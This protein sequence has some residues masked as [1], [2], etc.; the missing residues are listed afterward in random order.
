MELTSAFKKLDRAL[1][2]AVIVLHGAGSG[3]LAVMMFFTTAD[4]VLRY[5]FGNPIKGDYEISAF[6]MAIVIP[7]G[8]AL[9]ALRKRH[10]RVDVF[11][12]RLPRRVQAGLSVLA[13]LITLGLVCLMAWQG[14]KYAS[15]LHASKT[16]A[17]SI[18]V[19]HYPFVIVVTVC[20]AVFAVVALRHVIDYARQAITG[21]VAAEEEEIGPGGAE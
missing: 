12:M 6:M 5:F 17:T 2:R 13:Y 14:A 8:L 3:I 7:A 15:V 1:R 10:I 18:P 9:C 21:R 16:A 20:L 19:K 4:V 11:T